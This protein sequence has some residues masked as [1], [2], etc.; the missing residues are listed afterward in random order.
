MPDSGVAQRVGVIELG[1]LL[2]LLGHVAGRFDEGVGLAGGAQ[3]LAAV[4]DLLQDLL[5]LVVG[6]TTTLDDLADAIA[7]GIKVQSHV[8]S[9]PW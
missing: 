1:V 5:G 6:E 2:Q 7:E 8:R 4:G 3:L 9:P